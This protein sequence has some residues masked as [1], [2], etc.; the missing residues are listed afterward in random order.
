MN[1]YILLLL[2]VSFTSCS[3]FQGPENISGS[4]YMGKDSQESI[5][6]NN[7]K[8]ILRGFSDF[9]DTLSYGTWKKEGNMLVLDSDKKICSDFFD[10]EVQ[11]SFSGSKDSVYISIEN[12]PDGL[13]DAAD[14]F[15]PYL[16]YHV[17]RFFSY[18]QGNESIPFIRNITLLNEPSLLEFNLT[19]IPNLAIYDMKISGKAFV[20]YKYQIKSP[21]NNTFKI[22]ILDFDKRYFAYRRF[23]GEYVKVIDKNTLLW[24]NELYIRNKN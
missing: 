21:K 16:Y 18:N 10:V 15:T 3:V 24:D 4:S 23:K 9:I 11:E 13:T 2:I 8:F 5:E 22:R 7:D 20:T 19:I 12:K 17:N 14:V 1:K 6:F